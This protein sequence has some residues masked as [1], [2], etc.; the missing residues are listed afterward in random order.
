MWF[1]TNNID[2]HS[3]E[4]AI[5]NVYKHRVLRLCS[6]DWKSSL[7]EEREEIL[8]S[9]SIEFHIEFSVVY[10]YLRKIIRPFRRVSCIITKDLV[11][12]SK[13]GIENRL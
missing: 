3:I 12:F 1:L 7:N 10:S 13:E 11:Y 4:C 6:T 5:C 9:S 8:K 2:S